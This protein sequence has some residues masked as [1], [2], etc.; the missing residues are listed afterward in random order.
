MALDFPSSPTNGQ[1]FYPPEGPVWIY[2]STVGVWKRNAGTASLM[3]KII[4]PSM[5]ISQENG[6][7][8][9]AASAFLGYYPADQWAGVCSLATGTARSYRSFAPLI[10]SNYVC[11]DTT[12]GATLTALHYA[13]NRQSIEG[14]RIADLGWGTANAGQVILQAT[15][16]STA[17]GVFTLRIGNAPLPPTRSYLKEFTLAAGV[18]TEIV[19]VIPGD[20]AGTW[21]TNTNLGMIIDFTAGA[22]SNYRASGVGWQ[23][24]N[25]YAGP[26]QSNLLA[27]AGNALFVAKVGLYADPNMTGVAPEFQV[28]NYED[29]LQDCLRYWYKA[30]RMDGVVNTT[31]A[32][33]V[34]MSHYVPMRATPTRTLVGNVRLH[35]ISV[36]PNITSITNY[37]SNEFAHSLSAT[38]S[39]FTLGR[40]VR[41]LVDGQTANYIA[42]S[43]RM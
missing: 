34:W 5:Q 23:A 31:T 25:L 24:G 40:P 41:T 43:A 22:G 35:D 20:T 21:V 30:F 1:A 29:D 12:V 42:V 6:D 18:W 3:N 7:T 8:I 28:P 15:V 37:N 39:G 4:N 9:S 10:N 2:D 13:A 14:V 16:Q 36:A 26:N 32:P 17:G 27:G 11:I 38:A 33:I 19:A